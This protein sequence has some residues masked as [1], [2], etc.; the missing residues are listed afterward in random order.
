MYRPV[1]LERNPAEVLQ[2]VQLVGV[3]EVWI[4]PLDLLFAAW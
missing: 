3:E 1:A 4:L 2:R